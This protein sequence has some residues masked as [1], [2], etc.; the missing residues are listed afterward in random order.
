MDELLDF[1]RKS[2]MRWT[3]IVEVNV[4][5]KGEQLNQGVDSAAVLEVAHEGNGQSV[6]GAN[7]LA[8]RI[9]VEQSLR[10]VLTNTISRVDHRL[11]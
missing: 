9:Y 4:L 1:I 6:H 8:D 5:V 10:R 7:L 2:E 3:N 11:R